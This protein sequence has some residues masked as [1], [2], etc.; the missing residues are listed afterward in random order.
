MFQDVFINFTNIKPGD[1][2]GALA[3]RLTGQVWHLRSVLLAVLGL[4]GPQ[5]ATQRAGLER[6]SFG[7]HKMLVVATESGKVWNFKYSIA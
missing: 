2:F 1:I 6:D 4:G 3:R 7:L 5:S